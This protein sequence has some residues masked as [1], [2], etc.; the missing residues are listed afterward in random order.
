[1]SS[2]KTVT[3]QGQRFGSFAVH[4]APVATF[5]NRYRLGTM[6]LQ[7]RSLSDR[8]MLIG[9]APILALIYFGCLIHL[10]YLYA[11]MLIGDFGLPRRARGI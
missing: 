6:P 5:R 4:P 1:V 10:S 3:L 7:K 2:P 11:R 9:L 8:A